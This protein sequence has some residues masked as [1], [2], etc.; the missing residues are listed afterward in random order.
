MRRYLIIAGVFALIGTMGWLYW[1]YSGE[2]HADYKTGKIVRGK[3]RQ[4]VVATGSIRAVDSV[5]VGSQLSGRIVEIHVDFN[6]RVRKGQPIVELDQRKFLAEV[7]GAKAALDVAKANVR[8][9]EA[10]VRRAVSALE[11]VKASR[12]ASQARIDRVVT[13]HDEA[14]KNLVRIESLSKKGMVSGEM[15]DGAK[16]AYDKTTADLSEA[17]AE[18]EIS[19]QQIAIAEAEIQQAEAELLNAEAQVPQRQAALETAEV[20]LEHTLIRSPVDGVVISR[21]VEVGQTVAASLETPKLFT[22]AN[23]LRQIEVFARV[24]E[25][26]IGLLKEGQ[27]AAF[28]V[29]AFPSARFEGKVT[30]IR[31]SPLILGNVVTYTAVITS[32]NADLMLLPGM[33]ALI[34]MTVYEGSEGLLLPNR[35]LRFRPHIQAAD[36]GIDVADSMADGSPATVWIPGIGGPEPVAVRIGHSD[37]RFSELLSGELAE[38]QDVVI[39]QSRE[40]E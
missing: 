26:D 30:Q 15:L 19:E 27:A 12:K 3:V 23:D 9:K 36:R 14:Y 1:G 28:T 32:K 11:S 22:L 17:R 35:A 37:A 2:S 39:G 4:T 16:A 20:E 34:E 40:T 33:T 38:G 25:A 5:D 21:E 13:S 18:L 24:D 6:D 7:S 10:G 8:I 31:K 29:D